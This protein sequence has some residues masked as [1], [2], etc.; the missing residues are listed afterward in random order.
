MDTKKATIPRVNMQL[1]AFTIRG[2]APLVG[3][4]FSAEARSMMR[5]KQAAGSTAAKGKRREA[6]DFTKCRLEATHFFSDGTA[7]LPATAFRQAMVSACRL[8]GFKMTLAKLSIFIEQDGFDVD[9]HSPLVR[10]SKGGEP[11]HFE[12]ATRNETGVA[13]IRA[14]PLWQP[15][16]EAVV[17]VRY[18]ADQFTAD[19]VRNLLERVG[20]QVGIGAGRPD[21]KESC[22][23]G[24][25][26]FE[27]LA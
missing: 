16:W 2:N 10:F 24:W 12:A 23:Q 13:D 8:C 3:N 17:R 1:A 9:D 21:S 6:K 20:L 27:V 22:G 26:T 25:G 11:E 19:D 4:K 15:G 5:E 14:R 18:D 7:G